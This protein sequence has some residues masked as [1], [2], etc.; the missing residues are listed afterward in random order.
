VVPFTGVGRIDVLQSE[1][2]STYRID[3]LVFVPE[4]A[5]ITLTLLGIL[6]LFA[7]RKQPVAP[8][9]QSVS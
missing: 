9:M 8:S 2:D 5:A 1:D 6:G 7:R 3:S 4:P